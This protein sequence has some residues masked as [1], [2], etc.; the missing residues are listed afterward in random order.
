MAMPASGNIAIISAPQTCGSICA[1]VVCASGSLNTLSNAAGKA[2]PHCMREFYSFAWNVVNLTQV[3]STGCGGTTACACTCLSY[4]G[5]RAT[6]EC[7]C[8]CLCGDMSTVGQGA[9]SCA[10]FHVTCNSVLKYCC[11]AV[12]NSCQP[13]VAV[14]TSFCVDYNDTVN[15]VAWATTT[16]TACANCSR[17]A[18]CLGLVS[19]CSGGGGYC[20]G[21]TCTYCN[22]CTG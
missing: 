3:S 7:Y 12:A 14:N 19:V 17:S 8:V 10:C 6:N 9:S 16:S 2:T 21:T 5:T 4:S 15:I 18:I 13:P 11:V 22:M 1:A 20:K